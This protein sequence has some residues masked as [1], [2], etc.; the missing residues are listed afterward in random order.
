MKKIT[1][2][3]G[4]ILLAFNANASE[5]N[6][7]SRG[8][9]G[10]SFIFVEQDVEFSVFPDG[11]FDFVYIG[12]SKSSR[13]TVQSKNMNISFN[14]GYNYDAYVQY[15]NYGAVIQIENVPVYYDYYGR[16]V[17]AG[18]VD[19]QYNDRRL[20]QVGGMHI[21]YNNRGFSHYTGVINR[22]NPYY[23]YHPWH[24]YYARPLYT[25][26]IV[27]DHPYRRY[28]EP[29][30]YSYHDH[31]R[32]YNK[33]HKVA[34]NNGR[35]DFY[36]PGS[37]TYDN[38]GRSSANKDYDPNRK[39]TMI[40]QTRNNTVDSGTRNNT[41]TDRTIIDN[42]TSRTNAASK[43]RTSGTNDRNVNVNSNNVGN[44]RTNTP[45][46]SSDTR[47]SNIRSNIKNSE[48]RTPMQQNYNNTPIKVAPQPVRSAVGN[49]R[50]NNFS[51]IKTSSENRKAA[52]PAPKRTSVNRSQSK[53]TT[54]ATRSN[55]TR[56][57]AGSR[58][59]TR[60]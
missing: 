53:P 46:K 9:D 33:R 5:F 13:T 23:I 45:I 41:N 17:K 44:T 2:I 40:S 60:G 48:I 55:N 31:V 35:R 36:R 54:T 8:Y 25:H 7:I 29:V 52:A 56:S 10:N 57:N 16:I 14:S 59:N 47:N 19:I 22:Y 18:N 1:L 3:F 20:V 12:P 6:N 15:D 30:R 34:Y 28:Y 38:R 43:V 42:N 24:S 51:N 32:Y 39:N 37:R 49:N 50:A 21:F 4:L 26:V 27:Y 11:Q 58:T